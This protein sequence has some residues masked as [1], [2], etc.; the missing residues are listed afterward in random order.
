MT[1]QVDA[2]VLDALG[3]MTPRRFDLLLACIARGGEFTG[4]D[5]RRDVEGEDTRT[6]FLRNLN[7]LELGGWLVA[8]PPHTQSRQ[9]RRVTYRVSELTGTVFRCLADAVDAALTQAQEPSAT[10]TAA[11]PE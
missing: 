11:P 10:G 9:G 4:P 1:G 2:A 6:T 5:L 7:A 8:D 3:Q